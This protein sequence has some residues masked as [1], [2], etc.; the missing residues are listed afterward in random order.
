MEHL[1]WATCPIRAVL[2]GYRLP[3][4]KHGGI[5]TEFQTEVN[6]KMAKKLATEGF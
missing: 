4:G 3:T 5:L 6:K 2:R 1:T